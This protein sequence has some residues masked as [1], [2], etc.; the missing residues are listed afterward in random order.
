MRGPGILLAVAISALAQE[1]ARVFLISLDGFGYEAFTRDPAAASMRRMQK[2]AKEGVAAPMQAAFPSLT[3]AGHASIFT[4]VYGDRNGVTANQVARRPRANYRFDER[5]NGFRAEQLDVEHFWVPLGQ[6]GVSTVAHNPTQGFPCTPLNSGANVTL[7][8]GYQTEEIAAE[9]LLEG[10]FVQW[11]DRAPEA[12][13]WI[14]KSKRPLRYFEFTSKKTRFWG[15]VY[16]KSR[17]YDTIRI[18]TVQG[19][20]FVDV[21]YRSAEDEPLDASRRPRR[22]ARYFSDSLPLGSASAIFFRLFELSE[23]GRSFL[24]YQTPGKALSVCSGGTD[25]NEA[26]KTKLLAAGGFVGNGAG[27]IYQRGGFGPIERDG[28]AERRFMET[29]ELHARQTMAHSRILL[30]EYRPKLLVDYISTPDDLLHLWWGQAVRG[31]PFLEPFREWGYQIVDWR[32]AELW[33]LLRNQDHLIVVSDHGMT[34]MGNELRLNVLLKEWGYRDKVFASYYG[35]FVNTSEWRGGLVEPDQVRPLLDELRIR[36][37][38]YEVGGRKIFSRFFWPEEIAQSYGVGGDRGAQLYFDLEAG[39]SLSSVET[40]P[41]TQGLD[42]PRGEHGPLPTRN[43]LLALFLHAGP[44]IHSR[45]ASLKTIDVAPL[46]RE[47]LSR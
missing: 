32:V 16:A 25:Q 21:A 23:D 24:L 36:L 18:A 46:I 44:E 45:P 37:E 1:P 31:D 10:R 38:N 27:A 19:S 20:A 39:W 4:G 42:R 12:A 6:H 22:L 43:D 30:D 35:L 28:R 34:S 41:V 7:A 15:A 47:L 11:L 5:V 13:S 40:G 2:M 29:L 17:R 26:V 14:P 33:S 9:Q 8:N 3:A